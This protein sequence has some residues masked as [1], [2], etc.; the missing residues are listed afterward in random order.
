MFTAFLFIRRKM[1]ANIFNKGILRLPLV[2]PTKRVW[3]PSFRVTGD[4]GFLVPGHEASGLALADKQQA[5]VWCC[6]L[7]EA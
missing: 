5:E 1:K 2:L 7:V 4:S 3:L 6:F